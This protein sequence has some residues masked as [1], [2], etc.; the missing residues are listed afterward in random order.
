MTQTAG[1]YIEHNAKGTPVFARID[2]T[3]YGERLM[4]FFKEV[5]V[6]IIEESLND[7]TNAALREAHTKKLKTYENADALLADLY[8]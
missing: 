4:P 8:S 1:I 7:E 2:L 5:G 3:K 6:T